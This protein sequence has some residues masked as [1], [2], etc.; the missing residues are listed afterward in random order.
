ME[1]EYNNKV[2]AEN[3]LRERGVDLAIELKSVYISDLGEHAV[4]QFI[5]QVEEYL[6]DVF[7]MDPY[8]WDGELKTEH[9][10]KCF[11][12]AV[13]YQIDYLLAHPEIINESGLNSSGMIFIDHFKLLELGLHPM[14]KGIMHR[15]GMANLKRSG[16]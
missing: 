9:Q 16:W 4:E 8:T 15:G 1:L 13:I 3:Y 5:H 6:I 14:V 2:T 11:T 10:H 12:K 7:T